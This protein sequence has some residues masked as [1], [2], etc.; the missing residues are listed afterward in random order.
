MTLMD[1]FR[2]IR[3]YWVIVLVATLVCGAAGFAFT[4]IKHDAKDQISATANIVGNSQSPGVLGYAKAEGRMIVFD[5]GTRFEDEECEYT[6]TVAV[7]NGSQTVRVEVSGPDEA[8][9]ISLANQIAESACTKAREKYPESDYRLGYVGEVEKATMAN[10]EEASPPSK[11]YIIA[12]LLAGLFLGICIVVIIDLIRRP[13]KSIEGMQDA[14]ELPVLEKFP[15]ANGERLLANVRF[16]SQVDDLKRVCI[17]PLGEGGLAERV[18][19][20][21]RTAI[22]AEIR[23]GMGASQEADDAVRDAF[24]L[25]ACKPLSV[26]MSAA[27]E[28]RGADAVIIAGRQWEDNLSALKTTAAELKLAEANL[29]VLVFEE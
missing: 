12:A 24:Y 21:M 25:Q 3:K 26:D 5:D 28:A 10:V 23:T 1:L 18:A 15:A 4:L 2:L 6:L 9:C 20:L 7:E 19:D 14:V 27:Y 13:I 11:K 16:A 29:I 17:V 8:L 22:E